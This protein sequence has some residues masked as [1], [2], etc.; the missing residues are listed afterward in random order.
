MFFVNARAFIERETNGE[1]EIVVQ[2]RTKPNEPRRLEL[3]EELKQRMDDDP[4]QFADVDRAGIL[5]YL[6]AALNAAN[7]QK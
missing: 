7:D 2:T 5:Y 3:P 1:F 6:G 4:L